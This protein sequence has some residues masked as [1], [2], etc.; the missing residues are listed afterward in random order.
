MKCP[1][2][3]GVF[4][5]ALLN[6]ENTNNPEQILTENDL[7]T[8]TDCGKEYSLGELAEGQKPGGFAEC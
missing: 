4:F 6:L 2:C 5:D 7:V 3:G 8:C 1:H